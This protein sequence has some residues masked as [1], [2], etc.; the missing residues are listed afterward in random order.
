MSLGLLFLN[1]IIPIERITDFD[2]LLAKSNPRIGPNIWYD[3]H[4]FREGAMGYGDIEY[5][6]EYW[7]N[8]GLVGKVE[9]EKGQSWSDFC[10]A[11][12][13][14]GFEDRCDWLTFDSSRNCVSHVRQQHGKI[15]VRNAFYLVRPGFTGSVVEGRY[16][17]SSNI[18]KGMV[19]LNDAEIAF[20]YNSKGLFRFAIGPDQVKAMNRRRRYQRLCI[21]DFVSKKQF[22]YEIE[23][24]LNK[25]NVLEMCE[26]DESLKLDYKS[27][28][29]SIDHSMDEF[30]ERLSSQ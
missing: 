16:K 10:V 2:E 6:M 21:Y 9:N 8:R 1:I 19:V 18:C 25:A 26:N 5:M 27:I 7:Q 24:H 20:N 13:T 15:V 30:L 4:L 29:T 28:E 14:V 12:S 11:A 3:E 23:L 17:S 22:K